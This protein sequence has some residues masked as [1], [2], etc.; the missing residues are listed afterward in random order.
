[1]KFTYN[2]Q[3]VTKK[4]SQRDRAT[5]K[6]SRRQLVER[7]ESAERDRDRRS[8]TGNHNRRDLQVPT[9]RLA[10]LRPAGIIIITFFD[11]GTQFPRNEKNYAMQYKKY[12]NQ[13]G[14]NLAPPTP[15]QNSH[16]VRW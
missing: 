11:P 16:A 15:S 4:L 13:A 14:M 10:R 1:V 2:F 12:Q 7:A 9:I 8:G 5:P 3:T 6:R